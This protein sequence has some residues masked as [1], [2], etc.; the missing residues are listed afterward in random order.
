MTIAIVLVA[1]FFVWWEV[2]RIIGNCRVETV[3]LGCSKLIC[4][5]HERTGGKGY[6]MIPRNDYILP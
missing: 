1:D 2:F 3:D 4:S 5:N 6:N